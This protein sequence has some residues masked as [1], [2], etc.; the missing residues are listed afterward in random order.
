MPMSKNQPTG[1]APSASPGPTG[2]PGAGEAPACSGGLSH[3]WDVGIPEAR[4]IQ[5]SLARLVVTEDRLG[6]V[7]FVAG[8]D[9]GLDARR[10]VARASAVVLSFP[11]LQLCDWA[12]AERPLT[13]PY[14]PG[15]LSFR[16]IPVMLEA[17]GNLRQIPDLVLCDGQGLAHPRRFGIA[18]HFGLLTGIPTIGA[19]KSRLIGTHRPVGLLKGQYALLKDGTECIGVVLRTRTEVKPLYVSIGHRV[20]LMTA[21]R[22]VLA[23]TTRYRLPETTR[24]AHRLASSGGLHGFR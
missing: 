7:H 19:A 3:R 21:R 13:F 4:A 17:L 20:G 16:E 22:F 1:E 5:E 14:V 18:C 24:Y 11:E 10:S 2:E 8:M 9:V 6:D 12:V 23:C 15:L